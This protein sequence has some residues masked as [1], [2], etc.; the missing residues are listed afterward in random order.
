MHI[1]AVFDAQA[2]SVAVKIA[3]DKLLNKKK[4]EIGINN[5]QLDHPDNDRKRL[6]AKWGDHLK[7]IDVWKTLHSLG[8]LDTTHALGKV[9]FIVCLPGCKA[10][11]LHTDYEFD[12]W[13]PD[14]H[15]VPFG[16]LLALS[17]RTTI[18]Y[19]KSHRQDEPKC[20]PCT[21]YM[22]PG[23]VVLTRGDV[24]HHGDA[25]EHFTLGVHAYVDVPSFKGG[26]HMP[27][28]IHVDS[29]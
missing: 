15:H 29:I 2:I 4:F 17:A 6:F 19:P 1:K 22:Q 9:V 20:G 11:V 8:V 18:V 3:H 25:S 12:G 28:A 27:N 7:H 10:Q 5:Q 14:S 26:K 13:P 16:M 23:D 21:V 24:D